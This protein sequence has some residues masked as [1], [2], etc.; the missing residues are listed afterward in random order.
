M[1]L[2]RPAS[3][4]TLNTMLARSGFEVI[5]AKGAGYYY[6]TSDDPLTYAVLQEGR[7]EQGLYGLGPYLNRHPA[8]VWLREVASKFDHAEGMVVRNALLALAAK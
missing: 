3:L 4:A 6:V 7:G 2:D 8:R 1:N 5:L